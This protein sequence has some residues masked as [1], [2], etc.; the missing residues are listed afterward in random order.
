M[1]LPKPQY[2]VMPKVCAFASSLTF[3]LFPSTPPTGFTYVDQLLAIQTSDATQANKKFTLEWVAETA[4]TVK[5]ATGVPIKTPTTFEVF[6]ISQACT[7]TA[8]A[9]EPVPP[10]IYNM[11]EGAAITR[12]LPKFTVTPPECASFV[13]LTW[14]FTAPLAYVTIDPATNMVTVKT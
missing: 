4:P 5:T 8:I 6:T 2:E 7:V 10:I 14:S 9:F 1:N 12:P 3:S 13:Q 11:G